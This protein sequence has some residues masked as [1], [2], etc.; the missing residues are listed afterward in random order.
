MLTAALFATV[1]RD[2]AIGSDETCDVLKHGE[3]F[4]GSGNEP[5]YLVV[6]LGNPSVS[7]DTD[8]AA[9]LRLLDT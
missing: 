6:S 8:D 3:G 5:G 9:I 4:A 2:S 7:E 1:S